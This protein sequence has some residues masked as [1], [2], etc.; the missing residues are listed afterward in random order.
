MNIK[1][2]LAI[3]ICFLLIYDTSYAATEYATFESFYKGSSSIGWVIAGIVAILGAAII[4][5]TGGT[6][7]PIVV[8]IGSWIGGTMGLSGIAASN[9]GLALL[10]GGTK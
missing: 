10:G 2:C 1:Y 6:A 7:S 3:I 8:S 5:F 4:F 9:A